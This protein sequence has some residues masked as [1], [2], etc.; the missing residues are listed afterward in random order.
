MNSRVC[1]CARCSGKVRDLPPCWG[2]GGGGVTR[3]NRPEGEKHRAVDP[4]C[5]VKAKKESPRKCCKLLVD[6]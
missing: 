1:R 4:G 2:G 5:V 3:K 6:P